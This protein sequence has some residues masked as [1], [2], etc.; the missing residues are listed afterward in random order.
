[1]RSEKEFGKRL[2]SQ[3]FLRNCNGVSDRIAVPDRARIIQ[4]RTNALQIAFMAARHP[5]NGRRH[6]AIHGVFDGLKV[7]FQTNIAPAKAFNAIKGTTGHQPFHQTKSHTTTFINARM[8]IV[9]IAPP[10]H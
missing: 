3:I 4:Q 5:Q 1:M 2:P 9:E 7:G 10:N 6:I 8:A